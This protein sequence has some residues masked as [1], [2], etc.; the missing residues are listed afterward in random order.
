MLY[1]VAKITLPVHQKKMV[2]VNG[3]I[4]VGNVNVFVIEYNG[5]VYVKYLNHRT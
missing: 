4:I 2:M 3:K 1:A 5:W